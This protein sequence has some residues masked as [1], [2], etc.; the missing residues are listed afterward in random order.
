MRIFPAFLLLLT[1]NLHADE[2]MWL[3]S[4]PPL[5]QWKERYNFEPAK[6]W[7]E[8]MQK[9]SV[10]F[11][12]GG[13]GSFVSADGLVM[14]NHHVAADCIG[15][16]S[17]KENDLMKN[18]FL[19]KGRAEE[20]KCVDLELNVLMST[21]DV[22]AR[23][24]SA[25]KPGLDA[26]AAQKARNAAINA[27]EKESLDKTGLRS[28]VVTLYNGGQY[29]LYRYKRYTDVRLAFAPESGIAFFGGDPDNFEFPRYCLDVTFLRVYENDKPAQV[30]HYFKWSKSGP[31]ENDLIF[32]SGHP[33][34]TN[35]LNTIR[36]LEFIRDRMQPTRLNVLRRREVLLKSWAERNIE[37][38][39]RA[40]DDLM[41]L[42]NARKARM[43][44][45][46]GLQDPSVMGQKKADEEALRAA[47]N[48]SADL[49][50][51]YGDA[52]DQVAAAVAIHD[53][54]YEEH[55]LLETGN[56]FNSQLFTLARDLVRY[57]EE[58]R[59]PNAERL[60]EFAESGIES[61]KLALFSEAPI[62]EDLE[63]LKLGDSL[64]MMMEW[65]GAE[66]PLAKQVL[67][68][69]SPRERA[70]ELVRGSGLMDVANR[71]KLFE[72][73]LDA[74]K[75]SR[76][77]MIQLAM[78]VDPAA[79]KIRDTYEQKVDEPLK[80]GYSKIAQARFAAYGSS[81]YPD[82]TFTLRVS[83]GQVKG[84]TENG[85][86]VPAMTTI[87]GAYAH[88]ADHGYREPFDLPQSWKDK[89]GALD[90]NT[91]FNFVST[92]DIIGGNSGSPTLNRDGEIVGIIFDGNLYS[93]VSD[94]TYT[95][96]QA[97]ALSVHSSGI[98][99]AMRKVYGADALVKELTAPK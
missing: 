53:K 63:I 15:K 66:H 38:A 47:V 24:N 55:Y 25:V 12:N 41:S 64:S 80:Q 36:D 20:R 43:G 56:A 93:L 71:R 75:A 42:Q 98:I 21:D 17:T 50:A 30:Q 91:P 59:K 16:L 99:E 49:K 60:R 67:A 3:Y 37:N 39:R 77:P 90:L 58:S 1:M 78:L 5:K 92:P 33:G 68:G 76:D 46:A 8:H 4:N 86:P 89:K 61:L 96:E 28:D 85:K 73:G 70:A 10:R 11:N 44:M 69:K 26:A 14:T 87:G 32:V 74:V 62:Y 13:S 19:A 7:L 79:R 84:Y 72:G 94:Y 95:D 34:K 6:A 18:G 40:Q 2:G 22:T 52:W 29:H 97:R 45:L 54:I 81:V 57:A 88:A 31:K 51:K 83:Y 48:K 35:R 27:I 82:A 23:V 9:S 65:L